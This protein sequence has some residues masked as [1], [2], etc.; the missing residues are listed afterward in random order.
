M[1]PRYF[2]KSPEDQLIE[3]CSEL[4]LALCKLKRFGKVA[5]DPFTQK[6]YDNEAQARAEISDVKQ[7]IHNCLVK[8]SNTE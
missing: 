7:A 8:W 4:I 3:E 2:Q 1:D 6:T 5:T